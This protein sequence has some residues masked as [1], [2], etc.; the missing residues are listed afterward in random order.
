MAAESTTVA[1]T[2]VVDKVAQL[3]VYAAIVYCVYVPFE[4]EVSSTA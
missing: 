2:A 4:S 3:N 1:A